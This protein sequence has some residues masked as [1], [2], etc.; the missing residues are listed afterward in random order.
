MFF[1]SIELKDGM[2]FIYS[3]AIII[4]PF[5]GGFLAGIFFEKVY[6]KVHLEWKNTDNWLLL[7]LYIYTI[8]QYQIRL[9]EMKWD[10]LRHFSILFY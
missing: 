6:K 8:R 1:K 3:L 5:L 2:L 7:N 4:G 9:Y 10:S